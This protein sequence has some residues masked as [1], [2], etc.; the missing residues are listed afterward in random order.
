MKNKIIWLIVGIL[1]VIIISLSLLYYFSTDDLSDDKELAIQKAKESVDLSSVERVDWFHYTNSYFV[2][3]GTDNEGKHI[4]V[5]V[6]ENEAEEM[7]VEEANKGL[8]KD[9]VSELLFSGLKS[10]DPEKR[11]QKIVDVKLGLLD[12]SPVYEITYIDQKERYSIIYIDFY[13][14]DWFRVYNL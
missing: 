6:P 14:G 3:E 2:I 10:L 1:L 7:M 8:T 11:P 9:E 5:W 12:T 13:K 4:I